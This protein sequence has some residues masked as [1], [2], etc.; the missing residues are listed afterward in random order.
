[1]CVGKARDFRDLC[2]SVC[3]VA[4]VN[5]LKQL[6]ISTVTSQTVGSHEAEPKQILGVLM[7]LRKSDSAQKSNTGQELSTSQHTCSFLPLAWA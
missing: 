3:V 1:M 4:R 7:I 6:S 2:L 5:E